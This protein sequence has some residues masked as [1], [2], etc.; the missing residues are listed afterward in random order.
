MKE[1]GSLVLRASTGPL[2][3]ILLY[4]FVRDSLIDGGEP[5]HLF[6]DLLGGKNR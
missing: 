6:E 3:A 4:L 1:G 2:N 5:C